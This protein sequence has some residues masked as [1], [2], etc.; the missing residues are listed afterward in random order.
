MCTLTHVYI[1]NM[2]DRRV[3]ASTSIT[4]AAFPLLEIALEVY[5]WYSR[6]KKKRKEKKRKEKRYIVT[7]HWYCYILEG[8]QM[9]AWRCKWK[10][11]GRNEEWKRE[12]RERASKR[13]E[14][15]IVLENVIAGKS[16][17]TRSCFSGKNYAALL[18]N[19]VSLRF[20]PRTS[21]RLP[22]HGSVSV[23]ARNATADRWTAWTIMDNR[24]QSTR[25]RTRDRK[26]SVTFTTPSSSRWPRQSS[27]RSC[28][29]ILIINPAELWSGAERGE[30]FVTVLNVLNR[31]VS[32]FRA[33]PST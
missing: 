22:N 8:K 12:W 18:E 5:L 19:K 7:T 27:L 1:S 26:S 3:T 25:T 33:I 15:P 32:R 10:R 29:L 30:T 20:A 14:A 31:R 13:C 16:R 21:F 28:E 2:R 6:D 4:L 9:C 24:W 17:L 23:T 11:R